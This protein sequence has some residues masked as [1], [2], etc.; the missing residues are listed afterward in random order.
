MKSLLTTESMISL[1]KTLN[2]DQQ[3]D[4]LHALENIIPSSKD[5]LCSR[6]EALEE[7]YSELIWIARVDPDL[8]MGDENLRK[9]YQERV[10]KHRPDVMN[11]NT[12]AADWHHG[13]NSGML[14]CT[15]LLRAYALPRNHRV[16]VQ[17][18]EIPRKDMEEFLSRHPA[19]AK[20]PEDEEEPTMIQFQATEMT[21]EEK[22]QVVDRLKTCE[23]SAED[24]AHA[25]PIKFTP[26][27]I[28]PGTKY[29]CDGAIYEEQGNGL[30]PKLI[31]SKEDIERAEEERTG[32]VSVVTVTET[33]RDDGSMICDPDPQTLLPGTRLI[34]QAPAKLETS[35]D[36]FEPIH[37]S[38]HSEPKPVQNQEQ[39]EQPN[40]VLMERINGVWVPVDRFPWEEDDED[41]NPVVNLGQLGE[42]VVFTDSD[43]DD[44]GPCIHEIMRDLQARQYQ[45]YLEERER[46]KSYSDEETIDVVDR[47]REIK[48]AERDFPALNLL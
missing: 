23:R 7:K 31:S 47:K 19:Y 2:P 13:F 36:E 33:V 46:N 20:G 8:V 22:A 45:A 15:R 37:H 34:K 39:E 38:A 16:I 1:V 48:R 9:L 32:S 10:E 3:K 43:S 24:R 4:L 42:R 18:E 21:P 40:G 27:E 11:L 25:Q 35:D 29:F 26:P 5:D 30:P 12:N 41:G 14:A 44:S 28:V 17:R 6:L